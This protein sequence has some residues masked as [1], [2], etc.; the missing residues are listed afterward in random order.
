MGSAGLWRG[1]RAPGA[2]P[3]TVTLVTGASSGIGRSLALRL[4]GAGHPVAALARR[5]DRLTALVEEIESAGGRGLA[6]PCDVT[7]RAALADAA[8]R[9]AAELGP[10][11]R[12]VANAGGGSPTFVDSFSARQIEAVLQLNVVGVANAIE[13]VLPGMLERG[14]GHLVATGSLAS[15]RGIPT[16][17]AYSAAKS[18]LRTLIESLRVDLRTRGIDVTLIEPGPVRLKA[19]SKKSRWL[20]VDVE[21]ASSRMQRVIEARRSYDAFPWPLV[22]AT[23][24]GRLVPTPLYDRA[25]AGR[26]RK[27]KG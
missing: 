9:A 14:A 11:E 1:A 18:S 19:K 5:E 16:A 7:D 15:S 26:G 10:I 21:E 4:A 27:P 3:L 23:R 25:L 13:A 12:L 22:L 20:S 6:L 17:S 24:L 8:A 2:P